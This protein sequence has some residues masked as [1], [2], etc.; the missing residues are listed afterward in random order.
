[1]A[2]HLIKIVIAGAE[3]VGRAF[4]RAL[5]QELAASQEAAKRRSQT[6]GSS[7]DSSVTEDLKQGITLDEAI[8]IL[9][10]DSKL[11]PEDIQKN[12]QHL[13]QVNDKKNGGSFYLQS[14]VFR[15]KERIDQ[16][17]RDSSSGSQESASSQKDSKPPP[18]KF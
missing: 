12:Y 17:L 13:F 8:K 2:R 4:S 5:R 15:A 11:S 18:E 7:A 10:V 1:M 6:T 14:K 9:N 16:E 3:V